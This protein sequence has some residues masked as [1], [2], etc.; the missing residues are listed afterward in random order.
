[1]ADTSFNANDRLGVALFLAGLFHLVFI[2]GVHF[3][4]PNNA[5]GRPLD[6]TLVQAQNQQHPRSVSRLAQVNVQGGGGHRTHHMA[7]TPFAAKHGG[8]GLPHPQTN[9]NQHNTA[10][11]HWHDLIAN[12]SPL[13]ITLHHSAEQISQEI[14]EDINRHQQFLTEEARLKAEI[15]RDWRAYLIAGKGYGGVTA[16]RFAYALYIARWTAHVEQIGNAHFPRNPNIERLSGSLV[17]DVAVHANGQ[18]G[19]IHIVRKAHDPALDAA[20]LQ[21]VRLAAPFAPLPKGT[22]LPYHTLHIIETWRFHG[23]YMDG[24]RLTKSPVS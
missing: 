4:A 6:V 10:I 19:H 24:S 3:R 5:R 17:L 7:H 11:R 12:H 21:V 16:Q 1:M 8:G 18:L 2:L 22:G 9:Q 23:G 20:A 13:R 15:R 14:H